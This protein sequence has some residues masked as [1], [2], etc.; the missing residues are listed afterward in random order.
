MLAS[1][2]NLPWN[3]C[4]PILLRNKNTAS[5]VLAI[6]TGANDDLICDDAGTDDAHIDGV[7]DGEGIVGG[8]VGAG[9][10]ACCDKLA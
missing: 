8:N 6:D 10:T 7:V 1:S 4:K 3:S 2:K 5:G 9:F